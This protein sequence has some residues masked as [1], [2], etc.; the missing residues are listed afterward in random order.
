[1]RKTVV[2][3]GL[4]ALS[5]AYAAW[6]N[7]HKHA[8]PDHVWAEVAFGVGYTLIGARLHTPPASGGIFRDGHI[9]E[10]F[11]YSA[12]PIIVGELAQWVRRREMRRRFADRWRVGG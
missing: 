6:L 9:Y 10:A 11:A 4:T 2:N 7:E 8:E 12:T 3:L 5:C 1:M